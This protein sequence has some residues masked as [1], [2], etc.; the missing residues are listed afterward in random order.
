MDS[1]VGTGTGVGSG[2][3]VGGVS[4]GTTVGIAVGATGV[5]VANPTPPRDAKKYGSEAAFIRVMN[6][7]RSAEL[8]YV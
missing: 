4:V 7:F 1:G 5:G 6:W 8:R 3:A 2:V